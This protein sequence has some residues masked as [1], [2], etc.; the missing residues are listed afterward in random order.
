MKE[1]GKSTGGGHE[2][3]RGCRRV[4]GRGFGRFAGE[5]GRWSECGGG[6]W[7]KVEREEELEERLEGR[8][9]EGR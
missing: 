3:G 5:T 9:P 2:D 8:W 7:R 4:S 6:C 1:E